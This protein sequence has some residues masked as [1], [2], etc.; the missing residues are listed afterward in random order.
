M[1]GPIRWFGGKGR[2]VAK[3]L[4]LMPPCRRYCEPFCGAASMFFARDPVEVETLND[5]DGG[6]IGFFRALADPEQFERFYR[7]VALLPYSAEL[8]N[9]ATL[10]WRNEG[11]PAERAAWWFVVARQSFSGRFEAGWSSNVTASSRGRADTVNSWLLC[12]ERL[13]ETHARLQGAQIENADWRI[14]LDRYDTPETLMYCDPPYVASTRRSGGYAHEMTVGDHGELVAALL[15]LK[16]MAVVSGYDHPVYAPLTD[17]GWAKYGFETACYAA[18]RTRASRLQGKG[19]ALANAP[20]TESVW[21]KPWTHGEGDL[22][23]RA[24]DARG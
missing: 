20:R 9:E 18:G 23:S 12:I 10:R 14:V 15:R 22:L 21:V 8:R 5:L 1:R 24:F 13:P 16:G 3:I 11:D 4:P 6:L 19:A 7:R 17:A 2:M